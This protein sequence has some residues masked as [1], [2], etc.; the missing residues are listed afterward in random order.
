MNSSPRFKAAAL[1]LAVLPGTL[2]LASAAPASAAPPVE[3][4][5]LVSV[6]TDGTQGDEGS[7]A[8]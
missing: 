3:E 8:N 6:A 2:L 4:T 5:T 1:G 7:Y